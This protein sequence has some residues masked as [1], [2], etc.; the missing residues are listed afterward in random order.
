MNDSLQNNDLNI[1]INPSKTFESLKKTDVFKEIISE[2]VRE[3]EIDLN[4]TEILEEIVKRESLSTT[5]FGDGFAIPHGK[6]T[7]LDK[8][9]I[10]LI[11]TD[12]K[13]DWESL[14]DQPVS[15]IFLLI[16]PKENGETVHLKLLSKLAYHLMDKDIQKAF[17]DAETEKELETVIDRII[18]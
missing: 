16:V 5:G 13:I 15:I 8:P 1:Y 12:E 11:R 14:D 2:V 3:T 4:K 6:A 7:G 17:K 18:K 10:V 9:L